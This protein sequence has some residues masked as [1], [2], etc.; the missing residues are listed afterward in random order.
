MYLQGSS[1][2]PGISALKLQRFDASK[3]QAEGTDGDSTVL[4][5]RGHS[6]G[7]ALE[8]AL[9]LLVGPGAHRV[10]ALTTIHD[11]SLS[12]VVQPGHPDR[13]LLVCAGLFRNVSLRVRSVSSKFYHFLLKRHG[14]PCDQGFLVQR[15]KVQFFV[16]LCPGAQNSLRMFLTLTQPDKA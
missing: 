7:T 1:S 14:L 9:A 10:T 3:R 15:P 6:S 5:V 11:L 16:H 12:R 4:D 2:F 8:G 13:M